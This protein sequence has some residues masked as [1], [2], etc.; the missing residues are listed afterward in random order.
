MLISANSFLILSI[1]YPIVFEEDLDFSTMAEKSIV[2]KL[3][4]L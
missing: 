3:F 4:D 2:T 1:S